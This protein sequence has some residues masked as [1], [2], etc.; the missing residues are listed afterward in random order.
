MP[1]E[2]GRRAFVGTMVAGLPLLAGGPVALAQ[3][4][5]KGR[6]RSGSTGGRPL[7]PFLEYSVRELGRIQRR[8]HAA[9]RMRGE[10][11]RAAAQHLRSLR[12]YARGTTLDAAVIETVSAAVA[13]Q[14]RDALM[15]PKADPQKVADDMRQFGF[16]IADV[17]D[18]IV[19]DY[20]ARAAL[21]DQV[22]KEGVT[23][24]LTRIADTIARASAEF[25]R[26]AAM[27]AQPFVQVQD[28][29]WWGGF[30]GSLQ[31]TIAKLQA[32][33]YLLGFLAF[34]NPDLLGAYYL[35]SAGMGIDALVYGAGC[36]W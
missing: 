26:R 6:A 9:R 27:V 33:V 18:A 10:D 11:A 19:L 34:L 20:A 32:E 16:E 3:S 36:W 23:P 8:A 21:L 12:V 17:P 30:C 4:N 14:G 5:A 29:D 22:Q 13:S 24:E 28:A 31:Y 15:Y 35:M 25:D 2:I 1:Q 7:D